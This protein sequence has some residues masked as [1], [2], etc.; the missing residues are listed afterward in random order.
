MGQLR[1][2][3]KCGNKIPYNITINGKKCS[4]KNRTF[5]INCS[6]YKSKKEKYNENSPKIIIK[7]CNRHG[8]VEHKLEYRKTG[9]RYRCCKCLE[10][11][12]STHIERIDEYRKENKIKSIEYLGG[13]CSICGY[14]KCKQ[15][16]EFHHVDATKK[17]FSICDG[18]TRSFEK[19][20]IELDKCILLCS[21]CH[22]ELHNIGV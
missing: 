3:K 15:A 19:I 20:K 8:E 11:Y 9:Y 17:E 21:N 10:S 6:P 1:I 7:K 2:C 18:R 12:S 14:D 16:L 22:R 13:K 5:C 4:L